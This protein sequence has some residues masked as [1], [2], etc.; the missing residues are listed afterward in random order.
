MRFLSTLLFLSSALIW[1]QPAPLDFQQVAS[2]ISQPTAIANAGDGSGRLFLVQQN[3]QIKILVNGQVLPTP[4]INLADR[5]TPASG[6]K[7]LLGLAFAPNY[8]TTGYFYVYYTAPN[9]LRS[10]LSRFQ[11]S[12]NDANVGNPG[13]EVKLL[14]IAQP[15]DNHNGGHLEFSPRDG[16]L[17]VAVGDGGSG[18]D[19]L[20]NAQTL[21]NLL[22]KILRIDVSDPQVTY[23]VPADNPF[24]GNPAARPEIWAY[25][26]R[27]PWKFAFDSEGNQYIGDVGQ[28]E[29]EELDF[30]AAT[31][32]GGA[33]YGWRLKEGSQC[34]NPAVNCEIPGLV[35]PIFEYP[36]TVGASITA[37]RA[38]EQGRRPVFYFGDFISGRIWTT[39]RIG[40]SWFTREVADTGYGI[41]TWGQDEQGNL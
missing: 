22:G 31:S 36:H 39:R 17:Y 12:A 10:V 34:F 40:Q 26:L 16:Y 14:E 38:F 13:S 5:I 33:N 8:E 41:S 30:Q 11:V 21:S 2:G 7:G 37:G 15:F 18:G 19:P 28:D 29:I 6:E 1:A 24:V 23:T 9:P 35:N 25:G 27:N 4:F 32:Q 3:G 20:N